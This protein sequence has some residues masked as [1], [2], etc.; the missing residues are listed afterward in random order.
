MVIGNFKNSRGHL[1]VYTAIVLRC[2]YKTMSIVINVEP[3]FLIR[4]LGYQPL[5]LRLILFGN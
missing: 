4:Y 2:P 3:L 5:Y 1:E